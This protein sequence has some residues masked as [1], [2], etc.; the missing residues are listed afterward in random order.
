MKHGSVVP[1][2]IFVANERK[3]RH[4]STQPAYVSRVISKTRSCHGQRRRGNI[5]NRWPLIAAR[6][7][8]IDQRR[9]A[10]ADIDDAGVPIRGSLF[11]ELK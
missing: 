1:H 2:I 4:I 6:Q 8:V 7:Q 10:A 3:R 5:K 9:L 11:D